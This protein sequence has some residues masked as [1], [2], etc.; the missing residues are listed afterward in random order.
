MPV[1]AEQQMRVDAVDYIEPVAHIAVGDQLSAMLVN[2][3]DGGQRNIGR[4][5]DAGPCS[6]VAHGA[7]T[8]RPIPTQAIQA[9]RR[10]LRRRL[11]LL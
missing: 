8:K 5:V 10:A 9:Y 3:E 2:D 11:R 6:V 7:R 1:D 4:P